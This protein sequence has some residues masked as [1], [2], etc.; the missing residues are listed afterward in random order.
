VLGAYLTFS[1]PSA[2]PVACAAL[3]GPKCDVGEGSSGTALGFY[4]PCGAATA[5]ASPPPP[6]ILG[7]PVDALRAVVDYAQR[8]GV[9]GEFPLSFFGS[10]SL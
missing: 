1:E 7:Q 10:K 8:Q 6:Q 3:R 5:A 2:Q 4:V 9:R